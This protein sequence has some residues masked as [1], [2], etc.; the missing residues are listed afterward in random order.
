M[1]MY[2]HT[3]LIQRALTRV[4]QLLYFNVER[5]FISWCPSEISDSYN[6]NFTGKHY[7]PQNHQVCSR[8]RVFVTF[9]SPRSVHGSPSNLTQVSYSNVISSKLSFPIIPYKTAGPSPP[10]L[11]ISLLCSVFLHSPYY[12]P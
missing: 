12:A 3:C 4:T 2:T 9:V 10:P 5:L 7:A 8:I 6:L 11:P 1:C